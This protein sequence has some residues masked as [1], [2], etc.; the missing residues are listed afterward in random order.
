M[1]LLPQ[2][3]QQA[4]LLAGELC[5]GRGCTEV[6]RCEGVH[7]RAIEGDEFAQLLSGEGGLEGA[8]SANDRNVGHCGATKDVEHRRGVIILDKS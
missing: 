8:T 1:L 5:V 6:L 3:L 2:E 4:G 7:G